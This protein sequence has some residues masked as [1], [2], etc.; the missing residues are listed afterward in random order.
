M[1]DRV[2]NL[3]F[4]LGLLILPVSSGYSMLDRVKNPVL[5][6]ELSKRYNNKAYVIAV[7]VAYV[8]CVAYSLLGII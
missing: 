6:L 7:Y 5:A 8:V 4:A 1:L 2:K 3:V